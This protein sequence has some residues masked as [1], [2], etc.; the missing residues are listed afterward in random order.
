MKNIILIPA[1]E[2]D[3]KLSELVNKLYKDYEVVVVND[4]S[5]EKEIFNKIEEECTILTHNVNKGK[6]EALKTG[7]RYINSKY[8]D[9]D[10]VITVDA[11]GQ[12]KCED[13]INLLN[14]INLNENSFVLGVRNFGKGTPFRSKLGNKITSK[15]FKHYLN[16]DLSDTQ[17]GLRAFKVSLVPFL[18]DIEGSRYEYEMNVLIQ[19]IKKDVPF[20]QIPI[21]TIY[22]D[23]NKSSHY[24]TIKDSYRIYKLIR[25]YK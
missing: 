1:Y 7:L 24:K 19:C 2:P 14:V 8:N 18:L 22:L 16:Y 13:I 20:I 6:G 23:N 17:T 9:N 11:D 25:K 12:H 21:E 3:K 4:G 10:S 15:I 5:V